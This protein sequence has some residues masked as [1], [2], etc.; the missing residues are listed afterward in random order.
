MYHFSLSTE[1]FK[2]KTKQQI[3]NDF[4]VSVIFW[5]VACTALY[6]FIVV[7]GQTTNDKQNRELGITLNYAEYSQFFVSDVR[8]ALVRRTPR[9]ARHALYRAST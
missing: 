1:N 3:F 6:E 2:I 5:A 4:A 7:N 9:N 8:G